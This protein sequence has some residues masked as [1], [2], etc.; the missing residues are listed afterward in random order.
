MKLAALSPSNEKVASQIHTILWS[1]LAPLQE[2][3]KNLNPS[4]LL[5]DA[6]R[7]LQSPL[8]RSQSSV[9][10]HVPCSRVASRIQ[11][12]SPWASIFSC[13]RFESFSWKLAVLVC[14]KEGH[15]RRFNFT[16]I[17]TNPRDNKEEIKKSLWGRFYA[18]SA[19]LCTSYLEYTV[20]KHT[21]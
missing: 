10:T 14:K 7:H 20:E 6:T 9:M 17:Y 16:Y 5:F 1:D 18:F 3:Q 8:K 13:V 15:S 2:S 19:S 12:L 21:A 4:A 11:N